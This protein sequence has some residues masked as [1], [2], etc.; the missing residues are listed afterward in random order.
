VLVPWGETQELADG[1]VSLLSDDAR[2]RAIGKAAK[3]AC[4]DRFDMS[5]LAPRYIELYG[6]L[7]GRP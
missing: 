2:R 5:R 1:I 3:S 6:E 4:A 7:A